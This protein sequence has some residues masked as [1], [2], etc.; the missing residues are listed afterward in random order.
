MMANRFEEIVLRRVIDEMIE[1]RRRYIE[2][3]RMLR[4]DRFLDHVFNPS[5]ITIS[6]F[7]FIHSFE[8]YEE[9]T[10]WFE[11]CRWHWDIHM[12]IKRELAKGDQ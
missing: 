6:L 4:S 2:A 9:I 5:I 7:N 3:V 11:S 8:C 12:F 10:F 1:A